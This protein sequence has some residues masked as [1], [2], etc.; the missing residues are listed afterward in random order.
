MKRIF[1]ARYVVRYGEVH[2]VTETQPLLLDVE[3]PVGDVGDPGLVLLVA[4]LVVGRWGIFFR[5][6]IVYTV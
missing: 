4:R 5:G 6:C 3:V 2:A 1:F